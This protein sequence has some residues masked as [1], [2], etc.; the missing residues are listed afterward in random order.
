MSF[1][2]DMHLPALEM[3]R[4]SFEGIHKD[5]KIQNGKGWQKRDLVK[6]SIL[7]IR[8]LPWVCTDMPVA[9]EKE[10]ECWKII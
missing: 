10:S 3:S 9:M 7:N 8:R 4:K 5:P 2:V 6:K 1:L